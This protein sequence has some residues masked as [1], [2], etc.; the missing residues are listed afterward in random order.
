VTSDL[1]PV[2]PLFAR[3]RDEL[4]SAARSGPIVD[5][6]CGRG[7]HVHALA[8]MEV[9]VIA[10]DRNDTFLRGLAHAGDV[11][12]TL[13]HRLRC[14]LETAHGLPFAP[15][16][17]GAILVFHFLFRPLCDA[18]ATALVPGGL[19]LYETFTQEQR[20][21]GTGPR[22][23]DFLL[24]PG[25]LLDRFGKMSVIS[26]TEGFNYASTAAGAAGDGPPTSATARLAARKP[27]A[28]K[29]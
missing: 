16:S 20:T 11:R 15:N 8:A 4:R 14:D 25:E 26:H 28:G 9:P 3:H 22:N 1:A 24:A 2:S 29:T 18:I 21:L 27:L 23:A 13:I 7:R 6:A 12:A 19:L 17:C 10:V 5:L